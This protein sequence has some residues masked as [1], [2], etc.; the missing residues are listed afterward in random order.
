MGKG[1]SHSNHGGRGKSVKSPKARLKMKMD[2]ENNE[3][4]AKRPQY[5]KSVKELFHG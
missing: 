5:S 1:K 3:R 4:K 2:A